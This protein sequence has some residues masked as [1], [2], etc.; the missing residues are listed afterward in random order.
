MPRLSYKPDASFVRFIALGAVGSRAVVT[1]LA[2]VGHDLRPLENGST[3]TKLWKDIKRKRV[4]IPDLVCA[5]CGLRVESRAK[6]ARKVAMS[7]S[8][9]DAERA[10]DYGMVDSDLIA[11]PVVREL[12]LRSWT[13][14]GLSGNTSSYAAS[15]VTE[16]GAQCHVPY[17]A[18]A[19]LR[20]VSPTASSQ[21]WV[22]EGSET[23]IEWDVVYSPGTVRSRR[24]TATRLPYA[25]LVTGTD[26]RG[27]TTS[28]FL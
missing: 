4:R 15:E 14:N 21:K 10:W 6:T 16:W 5:H 3:D 23:T 22:T 28:N 19:D 11:F 7:H 17:F 27:R 20:T 8:E 1:D 26:T 12:D 18:V 24:L 2:A 9:G 25:G 13:R